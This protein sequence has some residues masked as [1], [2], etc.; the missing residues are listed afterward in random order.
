MTCSSPVKDSKCNIRGF[1]QRLH[2]RKISSLAINWPITYQFSGNSS[3]AINAILLRQSAYCQF[4]VIT[5]CT[6][7]F[8]IAIGTVTATTVKYLLRGLPSSPLQISFFTIN[9]WFIN[10]LLLLQMTVHGNN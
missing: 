2:E 5:I 9:K 7:R 1:I 3:Y 8:N 6:Y 4:P 10:Y